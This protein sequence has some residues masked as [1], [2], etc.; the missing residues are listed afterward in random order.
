MLL[1]PA[2][3]TVSPWLISRFTI[4]FKGLTGSR[5]A[6]C[7]PTAAGRSCS[8]GGLFQSLSGETRPRREMAQRNAERTIRHPLKR[9]PAVLRAH[10]CALDGVV[11]ARC[12]V[13]HGQ[14]RST[15][16]RTVM[17][18]VPSEEHKYGAV[19]CARAAD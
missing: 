3:I 12:D 19:A 13:L 10:R 6:R 14:E 4:G 18:A 8:N 5:S 2:R 7:S 9:N 16:L 17:H 11:E 15:R 1:S